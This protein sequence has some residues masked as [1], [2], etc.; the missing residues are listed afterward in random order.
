MAELFQNTL[1]LALDSAPW[2]LVGLAAAGLIHA[3]VPMN[4]VGR[5]LGGRGLTAV[6]RAA[7]IGA[8]LPLCSCSTLPAAFSLRRA[9]ASRA[10]TTS[11]LIATPETG[12]DSVALSWVLLGPFLA[13][14]RPLAAVLSAVAAGILVGRTERDQRPAVALPVMAMPVTAVPACHGGGCDCS[15]APKPPPAA[16]SFAE[17]TLDG[18]RYA[19]TTLLDDLAFWLAVGLLAAGAVVTLVPPD[20]LHGWG[21]G[22]IPMLLILLVSIPMYVCATA[23]TPLAHAMLYS[24]VSPGTVLVFLLAGPASNLSTF[25]LVRK[26]LGNKALYA[27]LVG[28]AGMS[29]LLGLLL[30]ATVAAFGFDALAG[31][32]AIGG[33]EETISP[34]QAI[35]LLILVAAAVKPLRRRLAKGK[36]SDSGGCCG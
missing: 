5:F 10:A 35:S 9:G 31:M 34:W 27:Y 20:L 23:S 2:L 3:W 32:A 16:P 17:R 18:L 33:A 24:G 26:E 28:V 7:L 6:L 15:L 36:G 14:V 21:S 1:R 29:I 12:V 8:P 11:F 30:D 19:F 22:L 25:A 13:V 4:L